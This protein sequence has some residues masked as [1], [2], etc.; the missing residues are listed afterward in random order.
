MF[1]ITEY[2]LAGV[3]AVAISAGGYGY[4]QAQ[5]ND[6]L[7]LELQLSKGSLMSCASRLENIQQDLRSDNEIDNL[8]A[9]ALATV[10][11]HW[12]LP[13]TDNATD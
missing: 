9:S 10:P 2:L 11:S 6:A 7:K 5:K 3:G 12:L 8:P 4:L 13:D 1:G